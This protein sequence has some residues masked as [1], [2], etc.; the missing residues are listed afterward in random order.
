LKKNNK[1]VFINNSNTLNIPIQNPSPELADSN[2]NGYFGKINK[3]SSYAIEKQKNEKWT[4]GNR[5][6]LVR[7]SEVN[8]RK[9]L[10]I[11]QPALDNVISS[12]DLNRKTIRIFVITLVGKGR[13]HSFSTHNGE[14]FILVQEGAIKI[15]LDN[16]EEVLEEG[17]SIYYCSTIPHRIENL[18]IKKSVILAVIYTK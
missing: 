7:K 17:D 8:D 2:L 1:N 14:D 12:V 4:K 16:K 5:Y 10:S 6:T 15:I 11:H 18:N 3:Y 13:E 9:D